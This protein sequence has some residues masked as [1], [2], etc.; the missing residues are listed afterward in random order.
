MPNIP[1]HK[2]QP[3]LRPR[4]AT[5]LPDQDPHL[6]N[7]VA[8]PA[9]FTDFMRLDLSLSSFVLLSLSS[10]AYT[11]YHFGRYKLPTRSSVVSLFWI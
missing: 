10:A 5:S 6:L 7:Y 1:V 9:L 11:T 2:N 8:L 3:A 4:A